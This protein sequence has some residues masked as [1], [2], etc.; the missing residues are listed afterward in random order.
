MKNTLLGIV[1]CNAFC[2]SRHETENFIAESIYLPFN[3]YNKR[4]RK[5]TTTTLSFR[6]LMG[7]ML[8]TSVNEAQFIH[9]L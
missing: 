8:T 3:I 9:S 2:L 7:F 5:C 1:L 6:P 4:C